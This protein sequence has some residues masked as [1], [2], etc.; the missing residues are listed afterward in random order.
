MP[1]PQSELD[2]FDL[3]ESV[4]ELILVGDKLC[5]REIVEFM[6]QSIDPERGSLQ[7]AARELKHGK[8]PADLIEMVR[9]A[10]RS[11]PRSKRLTFSDR[12]RKRQRR[13]P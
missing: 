5:G 2:P 9:E 12:L 4:A 7:R 8:A 10:A 3:C 1:T 13:K 11:A 6:V